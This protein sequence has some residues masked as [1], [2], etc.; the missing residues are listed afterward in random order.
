MQLKFAPISVANFVSHKCNKIS[1]D[2][3]GFAPGIV[4][5]YF[6]NTR[7][8]YDLPTHEA[9]FLALVQH[10]GPGVVGT[11]PKQ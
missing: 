7:I 1:L 5:L 11:D 8:F 9:H 6:E 2:Q 10:G 4:R 3:L